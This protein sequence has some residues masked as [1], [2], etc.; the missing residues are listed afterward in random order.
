M[1]KILIT[2]QSRTGVTKKY[3]EEISAYL[4]NKGMDVKNVA[5]QDFSPDLL[6][7]AEILLFGAWTSGLMIFLQHPDKPWINY[8]KSLPDLKGKKAGLFT[9]YILA[10]GSLFKKMRKILIEKSIDPVLEL[11]S[12]NGSLSENDKVLLDKFIQ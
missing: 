11:K 7:D 9:T 10:T 1:S 6:D 2:Y 4:K 5:I 3:A 12:K 8:A